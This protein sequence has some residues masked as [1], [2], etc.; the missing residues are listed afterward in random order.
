MTLLPNL[1]WV[2][3]LG[4]FFFEKSGKG[5]FYIS[6]LFIEAVITNYEVAIKNQS[7]D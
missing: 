3:A 2:L 5:N 6:L 1:L 4:F 7:Q